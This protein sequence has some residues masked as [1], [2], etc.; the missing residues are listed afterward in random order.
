MATSVRNI[1]VATTLALFDETS[2]SSSDEDDEIQPLLALATYVI[3]HKVFLDE[4]R[5]ILP[6]DKSIPG[7]FDP[8]I[9]LDNSTPVIKVKEKRKK[10][11][12]K[13]LILRTIII[14]KEILMTDFIDIKNT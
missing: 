10:R 11:K 3:F 8:S 12:G 9:S 13:I 1:V 7:Q 5:T 4:C 6:L 14:F 2:S